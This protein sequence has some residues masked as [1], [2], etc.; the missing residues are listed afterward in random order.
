MSI[1]LLQP[2]YPF[3]RVT[4][5]GGGPCGTN[6]TVQTINLPTLSTSWGPAA[7]LPDVRPRINVNAVLL[8]DS[9][10]L[11]CGGLQSSP[12]PTWIYDPNAVV[13]AWREMD[14]NHRPRHYHSCA[15]LLPS[16]KVMMAGGAS[17]AG[18][19]L[20]VENSIEVFSPP[21]LFNPDGTLAARPV[22]DSVNGEV[23][24]PDHF[25]QFHHGDSFTVESPQA[26]NIAKVVLIRPTAVT[27]QTDSEQRII[28]M[29]F[30][31]SGANQLT[32]NAP[33]GGP[34]HAM[35]PR[36]YYLLF[37]LNGNGVPSEGKFVHLH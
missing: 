29:T 26:A 28:H 31:A 25:V 12:Y 2:I 14:E 13:N 8:P 4:T 32:V 1:L 6:S 3:V 37:L 21:Y 36:G 34:A 17:S 9:T 19:S 30:Y 15:L 10:V 16:G 24:A 22:I 23:P 7:S 33:D 11:V 18:C 20:S 35:A 27:H 5:V